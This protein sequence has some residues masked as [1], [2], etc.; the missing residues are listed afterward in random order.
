M[1]PKLT[2]E[3]VKAIRAHLKEIEWSMGYHQRNLDKLNAE[4]GV[5]G[6]ILA[7]QEEDKE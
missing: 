2:V 3:Q 1:I 7:T 5:L 6:A 4:K